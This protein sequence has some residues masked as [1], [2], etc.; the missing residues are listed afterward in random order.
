MTDD[1]KTN[2]HNKDCWF[3]EDKP[4]LKEMNPLIN[5]PYV[6]DGDMVVT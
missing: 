2:S 5:L 3:V 1:W 4:S 6:K